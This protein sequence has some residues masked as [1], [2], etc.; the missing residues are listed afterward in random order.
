MKPKKLKRNFLRDFHKYA[1][2][3]IIGQKAMNAVTFD[4]DEDDP[5]WEEASELYYNAESE[6]DDY[7]GQW[8][9]K[10]TDHFIDTDYATLEELR[11]FFD[12]I[13]N[14]YEPFRRYEIDYGPTHDHFS[15]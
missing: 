4:I 15:V 7:L 14:N 10:V 9:V 12:E 13:I 2:Q 3:M 1:G 11:A 8:L 6:M 5:R